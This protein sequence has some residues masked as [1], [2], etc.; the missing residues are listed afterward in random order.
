MMRCIKCEVI[1]ERNGYI[2]T[3]EED[4]KF[5]DFTGEYSGKIQVFY[6]VIE[7]D[8]LTESFKTLK[9]ARKYVDSLK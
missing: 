9:A 4:R 2:I 1:E 8:E 6:G 7:D 3:R 5:D